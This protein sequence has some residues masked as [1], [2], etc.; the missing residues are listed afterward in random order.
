MRCRGM[1]TG[2]VLSVDFA[3]Q[4]GARRVRRAAFRRAWQLLCC[5]TLVILFSPGRALAI[6]GGNPAAARDR[7]ARATVAVGT[8]SGVGGQLDVNHC[9]GVLIAADLVLTAAHCV[10]DHLQ[11][12]VVVPYNGDKPVPSP[13]WAATVAKY[14]VPPG[15]IFAADIPAQ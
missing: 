12:A 4:R 7:L 14:Y 6:D 2:V 15:R 9:S 10:G 1:A 11:G 3:S 8:A 13:Y 5:C